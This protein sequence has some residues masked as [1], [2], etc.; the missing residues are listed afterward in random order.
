[1]MIKLKSPVVLV[2]AEGLIN[3]QRTAAVV[4]QDYA[5]DKLVNCGIEEGEMVVCITVTDEVG[6][7]ITSDNRFTILEGT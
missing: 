3:K 4:E 7:Q 6:T 1:M 5:Y 2:P